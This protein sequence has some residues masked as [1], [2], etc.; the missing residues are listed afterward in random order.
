VNDR[1]DVALAVGADGVQLGAASLPVDVVRDMVPPTMRLGY[2]AHAPAETADA[3][4][5]VVVFGPVWDTPSKRGLGPPHGPA[6]LRA[7]VAAARAPVLAI[8][9]IDAARAGEAR[10]AGAVGVAVIRAILGAADP[11]AATRALL[12]AAAGGER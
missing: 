5:D 7:A 12:A 8:G 4:A 9:G 2:S 10:R 6:G 1:V 11:G 3:T